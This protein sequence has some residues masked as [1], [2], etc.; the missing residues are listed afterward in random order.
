MEQQLSIP[1]ITDEELMRRYLKIKPIAEIGS[2]KYWLK[3]YSIDEM[4]NTSYFWNLFSDRREPVS[5]ELSCHD[6]EDFK[7]LH[8]YGSHGIFKPSIAE[9]LAQIPENALKHFTIDAFEIIDNPASSGNLKK[10]REA[11]ECG[12]HTSVVRLYIRPEP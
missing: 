10:F 11:M 5:D 12:Y 4:R 6:H 8:S 7:C 9:I 3:T 1:P 2:Q